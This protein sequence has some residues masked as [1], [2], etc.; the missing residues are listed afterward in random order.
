MAPTGPMGGGMTEEKE[1]LVTQVKQPGP[2]GLGAAA[3]I[4]VPFRR[5][6]RFFPSLRPRGLASASLWLVG[7]KI[8]SE[9]VISLKGSRKGLVYVCSLSYLARPKVSSC[10]SHGIQFVAQSEGRVLSYGLRAECLTPRIGYF[11]GRSFSWQVLKQKHSFLGPI[12][13]GGEAMFG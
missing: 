11:F 6:L 4:S 2:R 13:A 3:R 5:S 9:F 1:Q 7:L 12:H 10:V 8:A